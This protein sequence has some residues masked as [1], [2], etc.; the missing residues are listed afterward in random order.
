MKLEEFEGSKKS[1]STPRCSMVDFLS[2]LTKPNAIQELAK[3]ITEEKLEMGETIVEKDEGG[4][5]FIL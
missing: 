3:K 2:V 1:S 5:A 4:G